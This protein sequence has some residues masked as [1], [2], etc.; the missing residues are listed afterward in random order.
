[1]VSRCFLSVHKINCMP[2]R[3]IEDWMETCGTTWKWSVSFMPKLL[4]PWC[5]NPQYPLDRML[6]GPQ[7]LSGK[8][9][10]EDIVVLTGD[11]NSGRLAWNPI[12]TVL[13][14][15][16]YPS[17]KNVPTKMKIK[18]KYETYHPVYILSSSNVNFRNWT[19]LSCDNCSNALFRDP[20]LTPI[21]ASWFCTWQQNN[22]INGHCKLIN[23]QILVISPERGLWDWK[24]HTS[25]NT[26]K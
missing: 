1:M 13:T 7:N 19:L 21:C 5:R 12:V 3:N 14:V 6:S 11:M 26:L 15:Q 18:I 24:Y 17:C 23:A 2:W 9:A 4:H 22:L 16:C 20:S 8:H 25:A 10:D